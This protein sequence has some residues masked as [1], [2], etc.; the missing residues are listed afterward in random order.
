M[1][2]RTRA[3]D[4]RVLYANALDASS[5]AA[6]NAAQKLQSGSAQLLSAWRL[7]GTAARV[8]RIPDFDETLDALE[9]W[10]QTLDGANPMRTALDR[11][12]Q[13]VEK[14]F[15]VRDSDIANES[16]RLTVEQNEL[17]AERGRLEEARI[18]SVRTAQHH[19]LDAAIDDA[20]EQPL[21]RSLLLG[22]DG[23]S[24]H[25]DAAAGVRRRVLTELRLQNLL[26][27]LRQGDGGQVVR[28]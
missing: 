26:V 21:G 4:A 13:L 25:V 15:A 6:H 22:P 9:T 7:Y 27:A 5:E 19:R 12:R 16:R 20:D 24:E 23:R 3:H 10:Q 2:I 17:Q 14:D 28:Q 18:P 8:L 11:I 1:Q